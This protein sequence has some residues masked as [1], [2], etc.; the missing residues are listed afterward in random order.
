[1]HKTGQQDVTLGLP[2]AGQIAVDK[3]DLVGHCVNFLPLRSHV[4]PNL[5]FMDYLRQRKTTLLDALEHQRFTY[6]SLIKKL[7][8]VRDNTRIP[9]TPVVFNIDI[10]MDTAIKFAGIDHTLIS[11]P[12]EYEAFELFLNITQSKNN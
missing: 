6:G 7:N 2:T 4:N 9:L 11:N 12:R 5:S 10:G 1:H 8:I 3:L